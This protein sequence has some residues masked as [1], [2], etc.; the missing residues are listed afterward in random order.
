MLRRHEPAQTMKAAA[1]SVKE[2]VEDNIGKDE[3]PLKLKLKV[4][5]LS[6]S[7]K[8][9]TKYLTREQNILMFG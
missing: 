6:E 1:D 7:E 3:L 2:S 5:V 4:E 8:T 9:R